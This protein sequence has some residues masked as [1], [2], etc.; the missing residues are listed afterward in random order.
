MRQD[1]FQKARRISRA[2]Q[3]YLEST[4]SNGLRSTDVYPYLSR[5]GIVEKDLNNGIK[6]RKFLKKLYDSGV[7]KSLI[8]QCKPQ[9]SFSNE[10]SIE[11]FF[12]KVSNNKIL[13]NNQTEKKI[14]KN[15]DLII[16][17]NEI[18]IMIDKLSRTIDK[19]PKK[20]LSTFTYNEK[21]I[22]K[23]YPRAYEIWSEKELKIAEIAWKIFLK[24]DKVAKLLKRQ[25]SSVERQLKKNR[26]L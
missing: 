11:W 9:K 18:D 25:P 22:R 24:V 4:G 3:E 10:F 7:L 14:N 21:E 2:I 16:S 23:L 19:L 12:Y 6:F 5:N 26:I 15:F 8:P 20:P 13:S 17:D 1:E